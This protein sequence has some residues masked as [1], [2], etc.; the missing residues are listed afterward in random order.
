MRGLIKG[1]IG[2]FIVGL[3]LAGC[4]APVASH[5][6][7]PSFKIWANQHYPNVNERVAIFVTTQSIPAGSQDL[8]FT[9]TLGKVVPAAGSAKPGKPVAYFSS[10]QPGTADITAT[11]KA[12]DQ[13]LSSTISIGVGAS[14]N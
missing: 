12:G 6:T 1:G 3:C 8:S 10:A 2:A 5:D 11:L 9:T 13:T 14:S 7:T 4:G